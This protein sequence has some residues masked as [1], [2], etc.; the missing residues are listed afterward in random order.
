MSGLSHKGRI[1]DEYIRESLGSVGYWGQDE[2]V[3]A[4]GVRPCDEA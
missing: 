3:P 2:G 1:R 4:T